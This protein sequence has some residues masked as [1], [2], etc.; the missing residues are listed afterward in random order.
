MEQKE[1]RK[2]TNK[3]ASEPSPG[4]SRHVADIKKLPFVQIKSQHLTCKNHL[5]S[6]S[7]S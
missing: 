1:A 5:R 7:N 2:G 6:S 3:R 4:L